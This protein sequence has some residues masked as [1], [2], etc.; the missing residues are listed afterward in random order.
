MA[1]NRNNINQDA[2]AD[3]STA[4]LAASK[5]SKVKET[6]NGKFSLRLRAETGS[7]RFV[8]DYMRR[9]NG[10]R[11]SRE[12]ADRHASWQNLFVISSSP[13]PLKKML[14]KLKHGKRHNVIVRFDS[15][16]FAWV[17]R[18]EDEE[19]GE[20]RVSEQNL[21]T[22]IDYLSV[23]DSETRKFIPATYFYR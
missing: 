4:V 9:N 8:A 10:Q 5:Y 16:P 3:I 15:A 11:P 14:N 22:G 23:L 20:V 6:K 18:F 13:E 12:E 2:R 21:T 7:S 1:N 19:T 17:G